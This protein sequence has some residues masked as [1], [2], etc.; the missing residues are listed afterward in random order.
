LAHALPE[1]GI[2]IPKHVGVSSVMLYVYDIVYLSGCN[3][4]DNPKCMN[5]QLPEHTVWYIMYSEQLHPMLTLLGATSCAA[6]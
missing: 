6:P 3:K 5:K 4:Y 1:D 2:F